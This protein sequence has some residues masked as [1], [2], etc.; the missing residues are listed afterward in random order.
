MAK[1][2]YDA[3]GVTKNASKTEIKKAYR[4]LAQKYHPD[5]NP[6][7]PKAEATFKEIS[8]AYAV[9]SDEKKRAQYDQ[10]GDA[11]FHQRFSQ[12]DIFRGADMNDIF[13]EFGFG[14]GGQ[15]DI[16]SRLFGGGGF[17]G[18]GGA[19]ARQRSMRGQDYTMKVNIPFTLAINGGER[20]VDFRTDAGLEQLRVKIPAGIE[21]GQKLRVSGKGAASPN[22][23]QAGDLYL[24]VQVDRDATFQRDGK[25]LLVK[26]KVP[27]STACLGGSAQVPTV[28]GETKRIKIPAGMQ[29]GGKI[30]LKGLGVGDGDLY[31]IIDVEVPKAVTNEQKYLLEKL[32]EIGM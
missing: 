6:D 23:G 13:R 22:G 3:L 27:Y 7:D 26:V 17:G 14:G 28:A 21:S 4:R 25:D 16:F 19:G 31:A 24:E 11:D 15:E 10:F 30:R 12:E 20:Q 2:Y 18:M 8:E 9:L 5:R 1:D 29:N 32:A